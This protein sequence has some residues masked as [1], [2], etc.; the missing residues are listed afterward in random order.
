MKKIKLILPYPPSVNLAFFNRKGGG[1]VKGRGLRTV[2][3]V[4]VEEVTKLIPAG[5]YMFEGPVKMKV[6]IFRPTNRG[7]I[8]NRLKMLLDSF[9]G[10]LYN[11]DDQV[12]DLKVGLYT[13]KSFRRVEVMV[14]ECSKPVLSLQ[15]SRE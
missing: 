15:F 6:K 14:Q 10:Y 13:D 9:K 7:D 2:Y 11:D 12:V 3:K 5:G 1:G 4:F 8:D